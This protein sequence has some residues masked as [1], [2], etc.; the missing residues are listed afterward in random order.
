MIGSSDAAVRFDRF[1]AQMPIVAILRGLRTE[2]AVPTVQALFDAGIRVAEVPLNSPDP[3]AT[4]AL[5]VRHFGK[6]MVIGA[7]TVTTPAEVRRLAECGAALCVSPNTDAAVIGEALRHGLVP[8]PGCATATE[9]FAAL[10]A[11][12]L[13]LKV[14]PAG[15]HAGDIAALRSV[16]PREAALF[17]VG[18]VG[19]DAVPAL[20]RAGVGA[21]GIGAD[22]YRPGSS[23]QE[24]A[25]RARTVVGA[26]QAP[27]VKML[28]NPQAVIG[29]G[30]VVLDDG[31][32]VWT[33]PA[34][35]RLLRFRG[36]AV[37]EWPVEQPVMSLAR[38]SAGPLFGALEDRFCTVSDEGVLSSG[39]PAS[40]GPGCRLNDMAID[41]LG[42]L[43]GGSMHKGLLAARGAIVHAPAP[44]AEPRIVMQGLGVPNGMAFSPDAATLFVV[45]TLART[46]LAF[47]ADP[48]RG[49]LGEGVVVSDFM[50]VPGKPDGLSPGADGTFWVAMWGGGCVVQLARD[51]VL[52]RT[53]EV[54]APHV[55]SVAALETGIFI[56]TSQMRLSPGQLAQFPASGGLFELS[57]N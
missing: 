27:A 39:P 17:A 5:L 32:V 40:L 16:L 51:G 41:P 38:R 18:G 30:P 3:F 29:E 53:V 19:P 13:H 8:L 1:I 57:L 48:G 7:G 43:W 44:M 14:F 10:A 12:A 42:G 46:L 25:L 11:G 6:T 28:C 33:D 34:Q 37:Q 22:I 55:S 47:P 2:E 49:E 23:A 21:F 36:G 54:P 9:A 35:K 56:T 26:V 45:D 20:R 52:L 24:V 31:A 50:N 4:I 15:G